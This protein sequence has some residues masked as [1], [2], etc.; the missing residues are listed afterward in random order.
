MAAASPR[1]SVPVL[2]ALFIFIPIC[3]PTAMHRRRQQGF[4][5]AQKSDIL[6]SLF[7]HDKQN[8]ERKRNNLWTPKGIFA[9]VVFFAVVVVQFVASIYL[10]RQFDA[11][12]APPVR[13]LR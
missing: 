9:E 12:R 4:K 3:I 11:L 1:L 10:S 5:R 2:N 8:L 6:K 7:A 13:R